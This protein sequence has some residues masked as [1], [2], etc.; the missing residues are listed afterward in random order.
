MPQRQ[1]LSSA[2]KAKITLEK[3]HIEQEMFEGMG[4]FNFLFGRKHRESFL[5]F[6][7]GHL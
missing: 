1:N 6:L 2:E 5:R 7:C 4:I 3:T